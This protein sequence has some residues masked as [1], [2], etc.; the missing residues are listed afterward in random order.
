MNVS[1]TQMSRTRFYPLT[2]G[3]IT[4]L[5]TLAHTL[6]TI[7]ILNELFDA[8]IF[9]FGVIHNLIYF[10]SQIT[11]LLKFDCAVTTWYT[12]LSIFVYFER[13]I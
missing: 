2:D 7:A 9:S 5:S 10:K 4:L 6:G 13:P 12:K 3:R 8:K 11:I 1:Q